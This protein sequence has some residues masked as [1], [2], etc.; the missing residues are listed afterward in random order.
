MPRV[1]RLRRCSGADSGGLKDAQTSASISVSALPGRRDGKV[2]VPATWRSPSRPC[3]AIARTS[4]S[5]NASAPA[6]GEIQIDSTVPTVVG[7][8]R[9]GGRA[10]ATSSAAMTCPASSCQPGISVA[11]ADRT[12]RPM[13]RR[14]SPRRA[15]G[16]RQRA[17]SRS[18][19]RPRRNSRYRPRRPARAR[20]RRASATFAIDDGF[21]RRRFWHIVERELENSRHACGEAHRSGDRSFSDRDFAHRGHA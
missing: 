16:R 10:P 1:T 21:A 6:A 19:V 11:R 20:A 13:G 2:P 5:E 3:P 18:T 17:P 15:A 9:G 14:T 7:A 12:R 4:G 8:S